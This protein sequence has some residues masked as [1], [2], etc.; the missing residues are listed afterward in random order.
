M[1]S[2]ETLLIHGTE[3]QEIFP[4]LFTRLGNLSNYAQGIE[5]IWTDGKADKLWTNAPGTSLADAGFLVEAK[6][7]DKAGVLTAKI[8]LDLALLCKPSSAAVM[9]LMRNPL[10]PK[11]TINE[12]KQK[13]FMYLCHEYIHANQRWREV[14]GLMPRYESVYLSLMNKGKREGNRDIQ[15]Y[16]Y[17][18][19]P[20]EKEAFRLASE[21]AN[22]YRYAIN[23]NEYDYMFPILWIKEILQY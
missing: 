11:A 14:M 12:V 16:A 10:P 22:K 1:Q 6:V 21:A 8:V 2:S 13:C 9:T 20:Y 19:H 7:H 3:F 5:V 23:N 17:N 15:S 4:I 18:N